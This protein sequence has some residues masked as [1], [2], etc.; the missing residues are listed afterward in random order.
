[1]VPAGVLFLTGC[2]TGSFL[3]VCIVR[4]PLEKSV[5]KPASHCPKCLRPIRW[6][7]N[8]PVISFIL[9]RGRCRDC[10]TPF[11]FRYC[12]VELLTG[13]AFAGL[14][15]YYGLDPVLWPIL[16]MVSM[17]IVATFSD[18]EHRIIPDEI[19]I[20]GMF[21]GLAFSLAVPRLHMEHLPS[22]IRL[23]SFFAL[24][25]ALLCLTLNLLQMRLQ[26][27][28]MERGD[29]IFL[30]VY[31][32]MALG[33]LAFSFLASHFTGF[34]RPLHSL[35]SSLQGAVIGGGVIYLMGLA[36]EL[37]FRKEAMG[38]GDIKLMAMI[39]AFLGWKMALLTFFI[40][41]FFGAVVGIVEKIRTKDSTI[42]YGPYIVLGAVISLFWGHRILR[43]IM[44][45]YTQF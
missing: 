5:V 2:I 11:S 14:Y 36:G 8:I 20:G 38:G 26:Q 30:L 9:L 34:E 15:T 33:Q 3:N 1:M 7:D 4:W 28:K 18:F 43:W 6:F 35:A 17:F 22:E 32:V 16:A 13:A 21:L 40:S 41:P 24:G 42:A 44:S 45:G 25:L 19:S 31:L 27:I 29:R 12:L 10:Q 23:V 37:I 39:G